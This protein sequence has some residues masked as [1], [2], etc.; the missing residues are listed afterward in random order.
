MQQNAVMKLFTN[1]HII[2][3]S[4]FPFM[5]KALVEY[6]RKRHPK[7]LYI[8]ELFVG[9]YHQKQY[10]LLLSLVIKENGLID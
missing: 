9:D 7:C 3:A 10:I 6:A 8:P 1:M 5:Q 2:I 4:L